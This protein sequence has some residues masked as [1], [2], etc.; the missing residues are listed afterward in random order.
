MAGKRT[1][2]RP[3]EFNPP[4]H[5]WIVPLENAVQNTTETLS[6]I[7][8][9]SLTPQQVCA[10][11]NECT[12]IKAVWFHNNL[13]LPEPTRQDVKR[14]L[15]AI[16]K[17]RPHDAFAT[18]EKS[19]GTTKAEIDA[20]LTCDLKSD[21]THP[22]PAL[23]PDAATIALRVVEGWPIEG[24]RPKKYYQRELA[25]LAVDTWREYGGESMSITRRTSTDPK[26]LSPL[27]RWASA[28]FNLVDNREPDPTQLEALLNQ[29]AQEVR[30]FRN[31]N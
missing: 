23:I 28:I 7:I 2:T 20:A 8:D 11:L 18:Y 1:D 17:M 16:S 9:K 13:P 31:Y 14:T 22:S 19:D 12:Q 4:D 25:Q 3:H 6:R 29:A 26:Y 24:G 21:C 10:I 30:F 5:G 27:M 15:A